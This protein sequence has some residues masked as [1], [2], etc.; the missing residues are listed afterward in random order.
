M[1]QVFDNATIFSIVV[2]TMLCLALHTHGFVG[3]YAVAASVLGFGA[4]PLLVIVALCTVI[5]AVTALQL[6]LLTTKGVLTLLI[7]ALEP[8][9]VAEK[10]S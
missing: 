8:R 4:L 1:R 5:V 10:R 9:S 7:M 3:A 6:V 2:V